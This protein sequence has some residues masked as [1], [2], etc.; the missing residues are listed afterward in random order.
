MYAYNDT[1]ITNNGTISL[2]NLIFALEYGIG[3]TQTIRGTGAWTGAGQMRIDR[4]STVTLADDVSMG[5]SS[6]YIKGYPLTGG[7]FVLNNHTL[8]FTSGTGL[9]FTNTGTFDI[10]SQ[11]LDFASAG[12]ATFTGAIFDAGMWRTGTVNGTGT[13]RTSGT[14]SLDGGVFNPPVTVAS[15]TSTA[16]ASLGGPLTIASGATLQILTRLTVKGNVTVAGTLDIGYQPYSG[17]CTAT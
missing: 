2:A 17:A 13:F 12:G 7:A 9:A 16:R 10:G 6:F 5:F 3:G 15:G 14:I 1:T 8:T 11:T 4:V